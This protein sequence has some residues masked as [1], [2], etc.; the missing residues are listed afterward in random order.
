MI[1]SCIQYEDDRKGK[2]T[3]S[4]A[5]FLLDLLSTL[6]QL[7]IFDCQHAM[8]S[9]STEEPHCRDNRDCH[10]PGRATVNRQMSVATTALLFTMYPSDHQSK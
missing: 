4:F 9:V 1:T 10:D 3:F 7:Q 5:F 8:S 2:E 6:C